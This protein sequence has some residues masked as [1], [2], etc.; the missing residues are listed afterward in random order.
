MWLQFLAAIGI[1]S[2]AYVAEQMVKLE[3][4]YKI[5]SETLKETRDALEQVVLDLRK[6]QDALGV[7]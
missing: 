7:K 4:E 2:R 6:K 5:S 1:A 3:S